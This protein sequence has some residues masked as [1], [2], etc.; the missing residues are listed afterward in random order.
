MNASRPLKL[1]SNQGLKIRNRTLEVAI[2]LASRGWLHPYGL[3]LATQGPH[4]AL[5]TVELEGDSHVFRHHS[6]KSVFLI[7]G[8]EEV[9]HRTLWIARKGPRVPVWITIA[10]RHG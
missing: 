1:A 10:W 2:R 4:P 6:I 9:V 7:C 5:C 8:S 3:A